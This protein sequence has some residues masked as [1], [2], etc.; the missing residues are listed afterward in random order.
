MAS[1]LRWQRSTT[2]IRFLATVAS[3]VTTFMSTPNWRA[4][5]PRGSRMPLT[6]SSA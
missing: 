6:P 5:M 1:T 4:T 2:S 3:D